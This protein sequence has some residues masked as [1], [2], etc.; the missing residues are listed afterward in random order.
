MRKF[1]LSIIAAT[2]LVVAAAPAS[3]AG[4]GELM[5]ADIDLDNIQSLQRGARN[6][7]NYCSGC[8][9][10]K[11]V[12]YSTIAKGLGLSEEQV[13]ENLMFN[14]EKIFDTIE[15]SMDSEAAAKWFGVAPPDLS[16]TARAKSADYIYTKLKGYYI[17][18]SRPTG[19]NNIALK[20]TSMPHVLAGLQG[21]RRANFEDHENEDGSVTTEL[22]GFE[23]VTE[24]KLSEEEY[25]AFVT[26]TVAFL[27]Y[28]AEPMRTQR[29]SIGTW[30]IA[31]LLVFLIL[32]Y[33]LKKE[34][35]K[36]VK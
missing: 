18:E 5:H 29:Q 2:A 17:D 25:D 23:Q 34:I 4:G 19:V 3:A 32:A 24:G 30:V 15:G 14:G 16:L 27:A 6:F 36:D 31:F 22:V 8:H 20:G 33:M 10:A 9:S 13:V 26:D 1:G 35:W 28:V 11:Y 7:M 21:M 12:R